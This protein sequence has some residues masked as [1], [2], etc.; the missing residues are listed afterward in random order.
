MCTLTFAFFATR[1]QVRVE[2]ASGERA[3]AGGV[4]PER[5]PR[6]RVHPHVLHV[7]GQQRGRAVVGEGAE[8]A[9]PPARGRR[10]QLRRAHLL[11]P[12]PAAAV[13]AR[14]LSGGGS[15]SAGTRAGRASLADW[16][17]QPNYIATL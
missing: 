17:E 7:G 11:P 10:R 6:R 14:P 5:A 1:R 13:R 4:G 2:P 16:K 15:F 3:G 12:V 8:A 9:A